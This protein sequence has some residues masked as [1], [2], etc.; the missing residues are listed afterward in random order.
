MHSF[1]TK[2]K[3]VNGKTIPAERGFTKAELYTSNPTK[4]GKVKRSVVSKLEMYP[5]APKAGNPDRLKVIA[6]SLRITEAE[7]KAHE[8]DFENGKYV[9][10]A[11]PDGRNTV[12]LANIANWFKDNVAE[13]LPKYE[14]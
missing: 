11:S 14:G 12:Q 8:K 1:E 7:V 6:N 5:R 3:V 9:H 4:N 2:R 10:K 13:L